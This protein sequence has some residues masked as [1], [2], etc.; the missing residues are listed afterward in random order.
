VFEFF[1]KGS[2]LFDVDETLVSTSVIHAEAF[3]KTLSE[4]EVAHEFNYANFAGMRTKQVFESFGA[5]NI[6]VEAMTLRKQ[7][8]TWNLMSNV[9][10]KP[11]AT[12][13]LKFLKRENI[14]VYTVSSGSRRNV[15]RSLI[16]T[17]LFGYFKDSIYAEDVLRGKPDP[18]CYQLAIKRFELDPTKV[19]AIEDSIAGCESATRAGIEVIGI[20]DLEELNCAVQYHSMVDLLSELR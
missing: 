12:D 4:F 18:E 13:I 11:G 17:G 1:S 19:V 5:S 9:K 2:V 14:S 15:Q 8:L 20:S 7:E 16:S 3:K 10:E 6:L